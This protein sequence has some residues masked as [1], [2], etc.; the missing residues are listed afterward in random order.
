M[1]IARETLAGL[2][3]VGRSGQRTYEDA[4]GVAVQANFAVG[5]LADTDSGQGQ[6]RR[7]ERAWRKGR[8][9]FELKDYRGQQGRKGKT[10]LAWQLPNGYSGTHRQRPLGRQKRINRELKDL[11]MKGMPGN[12][13][14]T[15]EMQKLEKRY[16]PNGKLA[17]KAY[18]RNPEQALY[19]KQTRKKNGRSD[20]WQQLSNE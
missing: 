3:G 10:Y 2:S 16:F 9:V 19:W 15:N 18:G 4:A 8:A 6:A 20:L 7:Q 14:E 1:P 5:E 11:V 17:A 13:A 12:V